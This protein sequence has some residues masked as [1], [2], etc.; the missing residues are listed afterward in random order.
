MTEPRPTCTRTEQA[1][2][3]ALHAL[4]P[5]EE[6]AVERH[7]PTCADCLA[8]VRDT[9]AVMTQLATAVEQVD[10]PMRL[11]A[12]I[13]DAAAA[14]PQVMAAVRRRD[15]AYA[16]QVGD[17]AS[18]G[19]GGS[20]PR[21]P[22]S[23]ESRSRRAEQAAVTGTGGRDCGRSRGGHRHRW[24]R[25]AYGSAAA[26]TRRRVFPGFQH[27][28]AR[29][30]PC[31]A[32][33]FART[34]RP[35]GW[36]GRRGGGPRRQSADRLHD[37]SQRQFRRPDLR[38]VGPQG[39]LV[40]P[41]AARGVRRGRT[42]CQPTDRRLP[43]SA[44]VQHLRHLAGARPNTT[45]GADRRRGL[46]HARCVRPPPGRHG[47]VRYCRCRW[48]ISSGGE[49][50][51]HTEEVTGSI[52]VS[53]TSKKPGQEPFIGAPGQAFLILPLGVSN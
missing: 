20:G 11:R 33:C 13:L 3:W 1:V 15:V 37:R 46:G 23:D 8:A 12:A 30:G 14:T 18:V 49:R 36:H 44:A 19:S 25:D 22:A 52:P 17:A 41:A 42:Q 27:H 43:R 48:A 10:P 21:Q 26:A 5:D 16:S 9:E 38:S 24:S 39:H 50:F 4:E 28:R 35:P 40:R 51:V 53:P 32:G 45:L 31:P 6:I 47:L 34:A 29:S 2:S 7:V